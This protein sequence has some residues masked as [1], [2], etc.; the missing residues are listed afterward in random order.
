MKP[1]PDATT[2][3]CLRKAS[4]TPQKQPAAKAAR[5]VTAG[6]VPSWVG[7]SPS[8]L[9]AE[10]GAERPRAGIRTANARAARRNRLVVMLQHT[11]RPPA[12][13]PDHRRARTLG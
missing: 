11:P 6:G 5:S 2:P 4:S 13:L 9:A 10:V 8:S 7:A 3:A 12:G 1:T